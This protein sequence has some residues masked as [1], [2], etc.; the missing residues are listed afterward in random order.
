M[1]GFLRHACK[2]LGSKYNVTWADLRD[3]PEEGLLFGTE[4]MPADVLILSFAAFNHGFGGYI[5]Q[6]VGMN[7]DRVLVHHYYANSWKKGR[8]PGY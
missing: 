8:R 1:L 6:N 7:D 5:G 4:E 3:I 2:D